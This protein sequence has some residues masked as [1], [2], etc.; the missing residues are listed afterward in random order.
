MT[1]RSGR[2][3]FEWLEGRWFLLQR[4]TSKNPASPSGLDGG[5][6]DLRFLRVRTPRDVERPAVKRTMRKAFRLGRAGPT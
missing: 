4:F 5:G 3:V 2:T 1:V 6:K